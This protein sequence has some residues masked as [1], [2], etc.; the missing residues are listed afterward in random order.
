MI[1]QWC[2]QG[3]KVHAAASTLPD[4][5]S[6]E[7]SAAELGDKSGKQTCAAAPTLVGCFATAARCCFQPPSL[8]HREAFSGYAAGDLSYPITWPELCSSPMG[9]P[10]APLLS[11]QPDVPLSLSY[12]QSSHDVHS[13]EVSSISSELAVCFKETLLF[14]EVVF[15]LLSV[16]LPGN[17]SQAIA[18]PETEIG[19][20]MEKLMRGSFL[21]TCSS[22]CFQTTE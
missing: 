9:C 14:H 10:P 5:W 12:P 1:A 17:Y 21:H 7:E 22:W 2:C 3:Q 18:W 4:A 8:T 19:L 13:S 11:K 15:L 20:Q 16:I 6:R